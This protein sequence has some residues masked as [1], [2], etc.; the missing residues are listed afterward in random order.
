MLRSPAPTHRRLRRRRVVP[1]SVT[2]AL[3]LAPAL[4]AL[5]LTTSGAQAQTL[6][7]PYA[8]AAS[9]DLIN[10]GAKLTTLNLAGAKVGHSDSD[11]DSSRAS[12]NSTAES[13]NVNADVAGLNLP[14]DKVTVAA[15]PSSTSASRILLPI[16]LSPVANVGV[17]GGQAQ[18][19]YQ[20]ANTCVPAIDGKSV[21]SSSRT[22]VAGLTLLSVPGVGQ[23][24]AVGAS[25]VTTETDLRSR[26]DGTNV[27]DVSATTSMSIGDISLLAGQ[28]K[29][30]VDS[31]VLLAAA[32]DGTTGTAGLVNSPTITA[33]IGSSVIPIP[34]NGSPITLPVPLEPLVNLKVTAFKP[35][36]LSTGA[37]GE[38][39]LQSL[40]RIQLNVLSVLPNTAVASVDL[41]LA[42][43][44]VKATAP[45]GG[46]DCT[47][48][49][50]AVPT[51]PVI[52]TP[53]DGSSTSDT[54]PEVSGSAEPDT[55]VT[56][57]EGGNAVCTATTG[58]DGKWSCTPTDEL[59]EGDH[60]FDA[61]ATNANGD[62]PA[63]ETTF[64]VDTTAPDAPT[65]DSPAKDA[66]VQTGTP[67]ISGTAEKGSTVTVTEGGTTL[68]T[69][70]ADDNGDW[71]CTPTTALDNGL[72]NIEATATDAAGNVSDPATT[73]FT[74]D[75]E[76]ADTTAPDAP[77]IETPADSSTV[78]DP[79]PTVSGTA[80]P[81]SAVVVKEGDNTICTSPADDDGN[82]SCDPTRAL[83]NGEH[84]FTATATDAAGN[85]SDPATTTFTVDAST[86]D[87]TPP[88]APVILTPANGSTVATGTPIVSGTAEADSTVTVKEGSTTICTAVTNASGSWSCTSSALSDGEHTFT[89][90]AT[91]AAGNVSDPATTTFTV[92]TN[93]QGTTPDAP[94]V[95]SPQNGS[96][97]N[98]GDTQ[99]TGSGDPGA[100]VTVKE[101]GNTLCSAVVNNEGSWN[102]TP[103]GSLSD[104]SH[105]IDVTQTENGQTSPPTTVT[106]EVGDG[107]N[108]CHLTFVNHKAK[109]PTNPSKACQAWLNDDLDNDGLT[110]G[111]EIQIGT[112]P[113]NA[114]TDGDGLTDGQEVHGPTTKYPS[115]HTN[116][117]SAY[118]DKD[119][120]ADGQE[121]HGIVLKQ[122]VRYS[123]KH[124]AKI[125]KVFP[126]PCRADT[127]KDGVGDGAEVHGFRIKQTVTAWGPAMGKKVVKAKKGKRSG[128]LVYYKIG[129]VQTNPTVADTDR[130]GLTDGQERT[131]SK[132]KKF[133]HAK[134]DP[135]NFDTDYGNVRDGHEVK[136]GN[137]PTSCLKGKRSPRN[138]FRL[139]IG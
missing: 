134:S 119:D 109:Y 5:G 17:I 54:T 126:S 60:T 76:P 51:A 78:T 62:S 72:H 40:L 79:T 120:L 115:C 97:D 45:D 29:I 12:D 86:E 68:C 11:V 133:H 9:G 137:N 32:S 18:A 49:D 34:L 50:N 30:H 63:A 81:N 47:Q 116:P 82:W 16:N 130:D 118:T 20:D 42:P 88:V 1:L 103:S 107:S 104:G 111:N 113:F 139:A 33:T 22:D 26:N 38:A 131:G 132:N 110:N 36:D 65:I 64:T 61:V 46:V 108:P 101:G 114:D 129:K 71:S 6:P 8:A 66:T 112:D 10:L 74:V 92:D 95:S 83:T 52:T 25:F 102:C 122:K 128:K 106:F 93:S 15:P 55:T 4:V 27:S 28:V 53:A 13:W 44:H 35:S 84:T 90:T 19:A 48:P 135:T 2:S 58:T 7:A 59:A 99:I 138:H 57:T 69:T 70:V 87:T 91:D 77:V 124:T 73:D 39:D 123:K 127:D 80:E 67:E 89:A 98:P 121:V 23:L 37:T 31:P 117:L 100:T 94:T 96:T 136:K 14:V 75:T 21:L 105:T 24:G 41:A 125:G 56:V 43:M 85:T 3:A